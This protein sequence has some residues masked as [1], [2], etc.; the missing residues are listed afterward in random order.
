MKDKAGRTPIVGDRLFHACLRYRNA[1]IRTGEII[2]ITPAGYIKYKG[3]ND[4]EYLCKNGQ[5]FI[6]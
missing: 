2:D 5:F 6:L 1:I 3:E 4:V